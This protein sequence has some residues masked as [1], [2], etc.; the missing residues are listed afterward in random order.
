MKKVKPLPFVLTIISLLYFIYVVSNGS[1]KMIGDTVG[2]D[3]GGMLLPLVLSVFMFFGFL[4]ITITER[5]AQR[6]KASK[7]EKK[8]FLVTFA[9]AILYVVLHKLLGFVLSSSL[10][11]FILTD[12]YTSLGKEKSSPVKHVAFL[13]LNEVMTI[14]VYT[15][16][17][18]MTRTLLSLG[19]R[20]LIPSIFGNSNV[21]AFIACIVVALFLFLFI[22]IEKKMIKT[23][24]SRSLMICSLI[25]YSVTLFLYIVFK[26]FFMV[27][28]A[29]GII[30][31]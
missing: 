12:L 9:V 14:A 18:Y 13:V 27:S 29:P 25:S 4:A 11:L 2:G 6:E 8:I 15:I 28:M 19:R 22:F 16:F 7:E 20:N 5:P 3:P 31:W 21:T 10:M 30:N 1:S 26:Q 24:S 17:R 23:E